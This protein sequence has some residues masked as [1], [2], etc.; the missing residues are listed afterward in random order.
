MVAYPALASPLEGKEPPF[1]GTKLE[2]VP[3]QIGIFDSGVGGLTVAAALRTLA[4]AL[5]LVYLADGAAFPYGERS[6]TEVAARTEAGAAHLIAEGCELVVIACNTATSAGLPRLRARFGVPFVGMEPPVKPALERTRSGRVLALVTPGTARGARL[7]AL[8]TSLGDPDRVAVVPM[9]GLADL[10]EAGVLRGGAVDDA[11]RA[12]LEGPGRDADHVVLGCTHYGFL[13][14]R[15]A[16]LLPPGV[17][18]VDAAEPVARRVLALLGL[19]P[20]PGAPPGPPMRTATTGDPA[21][22]G[23]AITRLRAA[24]A[25]LPAMDLTEAPAPGPELLPSTRERTP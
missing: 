23:Q 15:L 21:R 6:E 17:E 9:P 1:R 4:P 18:V 5:R 20:D 2:P 14:P 24:G 25:G 8:T 7:A 22:L 13:R 11:L 10:V 3:A 19:A 12:A 16:E